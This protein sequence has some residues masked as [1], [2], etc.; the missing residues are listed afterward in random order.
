MGLSKKDLNKPLHGDQR[1]FR[2]SPRKVDIPVG[3]N[4]FLLLRIANLILR[5]NVRFVR[6]NVK[7]YVEADVMVK[8][9][10]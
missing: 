8:G 7:G 10:S 1:V 5:A 6:R 3:R 2:K 4:M 9:L